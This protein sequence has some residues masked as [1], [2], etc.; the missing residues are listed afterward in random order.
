[1]SYKPRFQFDQPLE[2]REKVIDDQPD[3]NNYFQNDLNTN[4]S[5]STISNDQ[6]IQRI[7]SDTAQ[8]PISK[9]SPRKS[10]PNLNIHHSNIQFK[11]HSEELNY[12]R[13][14]M[15]EV[16]K[17]LAAMDSI[18]QLT[19]EQVSKY[20]INVGI[21]MDA[22]KAQNAELVDKIHAIEIE[23]E[24]FEQDIITL[25]NEINSYKSLKTEIE[26]LR[27]S[28]NLYKARCATLMKEQE[29]LKNSLL[30]EQFHE[31]T[32]K[33]SYIRTMQPSKLPNRPSLILQPSPTLSEQERTIMEG[34]H[35]LDNILE[36]KNDFRIEEKKLL[37]TPKPRTGPLPRAHV[38]KL[39]NAKRK[40]KI[41]NIKHLPLHGVKMN[42]Q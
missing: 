4:S 40:G 42:F 18:R 33:N 36:D 38:S 17:R 16:E 25:K 30:D 14:R 35:K 2:D 23:K 6:F 22:L 8:S 24:N 7:E 20:K 3:D 15:I 13:T 29:K 5:N 37:N 31:R 26:K 21:A 1:M 32:E 39:A 12:Y 19:T 10:T 27:D 9:I 41:N 11:T 28:E 34:I